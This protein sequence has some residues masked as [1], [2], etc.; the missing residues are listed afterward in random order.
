MTLPTNQFPQEDLHPQFLC[1]QFQ[2]IFCGFHCWDMGSLPCCQKSG[3]ASFLISALRLEPF[4]RKLP[5]YKESV[6]N[7][8]AVTGDKCPPIPMNQIN[9]HLKSS[10]HYLKF[11][12]V[13]YFFGKF[14]PIFAFSNHSNYFL[15]KSLPPN[16][17]CSNYHHP[18][19][20][21]REKHIWGCST[22][23]FILSTIDICK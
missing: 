21:E 20:S 12:G 18:C 11:L 4:H 22:E 1:F 5:K 7:L 14:T 10:L 9:F 8:R 2:I 3:N 19:L 17:S 6:Q 23:F 13:R 16:V 15:S